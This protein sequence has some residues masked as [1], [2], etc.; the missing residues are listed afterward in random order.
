MSEGKPFCYHITFGT[1]GWP[2]AV[3]AEED[4][5]DMHIAMKNGQ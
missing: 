1:T 5:S 2:W 4:E 3:A